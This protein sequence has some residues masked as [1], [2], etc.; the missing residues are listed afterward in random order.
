M[1]FSYRLV[2]R[3]SPDQGCRGSL[4][5]LDGIILP[6]KRVQYELCTLGRKSE[7]K[8]RSV[9]TLEI[10]DP[11]SSGLRGK[12]CDVAERSLDWWACGKTRG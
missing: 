8:C 10:V 4:T 2:S 9:G 12:W 1:E 3:S 7:E 6:P 5:L 11:Y